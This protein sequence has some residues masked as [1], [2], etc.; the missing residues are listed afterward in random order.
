M[1]SENDLKMGVCTLLDNLTDK[2]ELEVTSMSFDTPKEV[3]N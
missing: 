1:Y 3:D 2:E